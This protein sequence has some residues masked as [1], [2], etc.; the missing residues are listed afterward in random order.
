MSGIRIERLAWL[1][2][3]SS[4]RPWLFGW[5]ALLPQMHGRCLR[6][7]YLACY[8]S[9]RLS[10]RGVGISVDFA[11]AEGIV[12][13][14]CMLKTHPRATCT[15][16]A[17]WCMFAFWLAAVAEQVSLIL[18]DL[19]QFLA[20]GVLFQLGCGVQRVALGW[21]LYLLQMRIMGIRSS[22]QTSSPH[23][24]I[25]IMCLS[26][27]IHNISPFHSWSYVVSLSVLCTAWVAYTALTC[28]S[29]ALKLSLLL[30][31]TSRVRGSARKQAIW[32]AHV[33]G[34]EMLICAVLGLGICVYGMFSGMCLRA[35]W[36][37]RASSSEANLW[38]MT[39]FEQ[40]RSRLAGKLDTAYWVCAF[41][42]NQHASICAG[43]GPDR[44]RG[45]RSGPLWT[46]SAMTQSPARHLYS[47]TVMWKSVQPH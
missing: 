23:M 36:R 10:M 22:L 45:R 5:Q 44:R 24:W 2:P 12:R 46:G 9:G 19:A 38:L 25:H 14:C 15:H 8:V 26:W 43:F 41:C 13:Y 37:D 7:G 17:K 39:G 32:A 35:M 27:F 31:E 42:I 34:M 29:L 1:M 33:V 47:A 6:L 16:G 28:R 21:T 4:A 20:A 30:Q 11:P 40:V 3:R 18:S